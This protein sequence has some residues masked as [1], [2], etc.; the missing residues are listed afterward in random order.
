MWQST[1]KTPVVYFPPRFSTMKS[2]SLISFGGQRGTV[3]NS[4]KRSSLKAAT[5]N[6]SFYPPPQFL[7]KVS[8][9]LQFCKLK[10]TNLE[11]SCCIWPVVSNLKFPWEIADLLR[12]L[13]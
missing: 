2:I 10:C 13:S 4:L 6:P 5:Q 9:G 11:K 12:Q 8:F 7:S 1:R 3:N